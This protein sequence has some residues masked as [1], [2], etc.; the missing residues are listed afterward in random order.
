MYVQILR[1]KYFKPF[2]LC[3]VHV[4]QM[5]SYKVLNEVPANIS[6]V[7]LIF[8]IYVSLIKQAFVGNP[9]NSSN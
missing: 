5:S 3:V 2:I 9:H 6:H 8:K 4:R 7:L 1:L